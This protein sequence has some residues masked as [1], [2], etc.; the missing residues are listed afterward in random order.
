MSLQNVWHVGLLSACSCLGLVSGGVCFILLSFDIV[1][2]GFLHLL[3]SWLGFFHL[4]PWII[5]VSLLFA[6]FLSPFGT[7]Y[8]IQDTLRQITD[9]TKCREV[10]VWIGDNVRA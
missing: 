6:I 4:I 3:P 5:V 2:H 10:S 8:A 1:D 9:E 7:K